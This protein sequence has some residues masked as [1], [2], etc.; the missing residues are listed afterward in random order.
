MTTRQSRLR[1]AGAPGETSRCQASDLLGAMR[2]AG[3]VGKAIVLAVRGDPFEDRAL[4]RHRPEDAQRRSDRTRACTGLP[5][6][7]ATSLH[8]RGGR[9]GKDHRAHHDGRTTYARS[10]SSPRPSRSRPSSRCRIGAIKGVGTT[11]LRVSPTSEVKTRYWPLRLTLCRCPPTFGLPA[12]RTKAPRSPMFGRCATR[13][14]AVY[15]AGG[16]STSALRSEAA[17]VPVK[18][19]RSWSATSS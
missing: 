18:R 8:G 10:G 16:T 2:V 6:T 14:A 12:R 4:D 13:A 1:I 5:P 7:P 11:N 15:A 17:G 3:V 19:S 9:Q